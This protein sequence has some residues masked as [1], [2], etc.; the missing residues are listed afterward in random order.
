MRKIG[1]TPA[2]QKIIDYAYAYTRSKDFIYTL[3]AENG[4]WDPNRP[5]IAVGS[6]GYR[7]VGLCQLN[8]KY[9]SNFIDSK[10]FGDYKKQIKYCWEVW[11]DAEKKGRLRTTFYGYNNIHKTKNNFTLVTK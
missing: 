9:H 5:S 3:E 6:N 7:D 4:H 10:D 11:K 8:R 1:A 2:Q